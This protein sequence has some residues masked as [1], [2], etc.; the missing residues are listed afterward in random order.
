MMIVIM[1]IITD[2]DQKKSHQTQYKKACVGPQ[3]LFCVFQIKKNDFGGGKYKI[4]I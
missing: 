4:Y 1:I 3:N 2:D